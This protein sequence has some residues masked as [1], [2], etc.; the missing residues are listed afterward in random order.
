MI[1]SAIVLVLLTAAV[2][3]LPA[4]W[5]ISRQ[6]DRQAWAQLDQGRPTTQALYTARETELI[7]LA[8]LMA[9]RPTL[10]E[11]LLKKDLDALQDYLQTLQIGARSDLVIVCDTSGSVVASVG[12]EMSAE[13]CAL[14][15][16]TDVYSDIRMNIPRVLL[17]AMS[18]V[19]G[20]DADI[21]QVIAGIA[22]NNTFAE[23]MRAQT[24]LEHTIFLDGQLVS[25]SFSSDLDEL[26]KATRQMATDGDTTEG[27]RTIFNLLGEPYYALRLPIID[28][29]LEAEVILGVGDIIATRQRLVWTLAGSI[30]SIAVAG[31]IFGAYLA[32]RIGSTFTSL[33]EAAEAFS[34]GDLDTPVMVE[35]RVREA[36]LVAQ[37]LDSARVDLRRTLRQVQQEKAWTD[38]LLDGIVEGIVILDDSRRITFF[39]PGAE[40]ITGWRREQVIQRSCDEFFRPVE[41]KDL[42]RDLIPSPG[43]RCRILVELADR[44]QATLAI[45]GAQLAPSGAG[46]AEVVLVIRDI[47]EE[48]AVHRLLGHFM[49]NVSHEFRTPL[50]SL[51]ASI[52]LLMDQASDLT[53]SELHELLNSLHLGILGLRT[54]VDNLLESG[55]IETGH[56][57]VSPRPMDL[58]EIIGE[59]ARIMQPLLDK[60][61][62]FLSVELPKTIPMVHADPK[63]VLQV[64][65]NL[66]SNANLYSPDGTEIS[67]RVKIQDGWVQ[68]N[69]ADRG[70]GIL[71]EHRD[72]VFRRFPH[73]DSRAD[74]VQQGAGLGLSVVK[75]IIEA[76]QGQVGWKDH[77]GG[78][79]IFWFTLPSKREE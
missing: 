24:G 40:R 78:G 15:K 43:R 64:M 49:A 10:H 38:Q 51:A 76:H 22:L 36:S 34:K 37:A 16:P 60:R 59:A 13:A 46:E 73:I 29:G 5:L 41:T 62:Q 18:P 12:Y 2:A 74:E 32:R 23:Q 35:T 47:S 28:E 8:T 77:P 25:T 21:G 45:T 79:S 33:T 69:V 54:L 42:F 19:V 72:D 61:D 52:E 27:V 67:I 4:I 26:S 6:L 11:L 30:L 65:V 53:Y 9:Q 55:N 57:R 56:L 44:Q 7:S 68:L 48:E 39:S 75:A 63:R 1:F 71:S 58:A 50:S 20:D 17:L 66:L 3:S 70:S 31:S 14:N